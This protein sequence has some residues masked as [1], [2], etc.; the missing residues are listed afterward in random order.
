[1]NRLL[2]LPGY[3]EDAG[4]FENLRPRLPAGLPVEVIDNEMVFASWRPRDRPDV[5][6]L[7]R[8]VAA[9]FQIGPAD[10]L[11]GHSMG[12]W[13][14]I[15]LKQLTGAR[16][17]LINS[18]TDQR[19]IV[20][21]IRHPRLLG[22]YVWTGLMQSRWMRARFKRDYRRDESRA[23]HAGLVDGL[24]RH[25]RRFIHQ[26]LQV[27]FAPAPPL[28]VQPDLRL[29]ARRDNVIRPPDEPFIELPG[30]HFAHV[31]YP[32]LAAAAIAKVVGD[33]VMR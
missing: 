32:E 26:Q 8:H 31:F 19:K 16:A 17:I 13:L 6:Q 27:L 10:V 20:S 24:A 21:A 5:G 22:F 25:R 33:G 4:I 14:A 23:L 28:T 15:H 12:G 2:L 7:A 29:H 1:M 30:D 9:Q 18:F 11:I 3:L